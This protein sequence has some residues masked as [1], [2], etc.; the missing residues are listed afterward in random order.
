[1]GAAAQLAHSN[2]LQDAVLH[3]L[4]PV[5]VLI[6]HLP[7]TAPYQLSGTATFGGV[8]WT[9]NPRHHIQHLTG[10]VVQ[11][12]HGA[13]SR[14]PGRC[15]SH[16]TDP[17]PQARFQLGQ[18][19]ILTLWGTTS[20]IRL[21]PVPH[22]YGLWWASCFISSRPNLLGQLGRPL[23]HLGCIGKV[24]AD[25]STPGP[26]PKT[27]VLCRPHLDCVGKVQALR[28]GC[29]P[30]QG[31]EPVQVVARDVELAAGRLQ[32]AQLVQLLLRQ[33]THARDCGHLGLD[34]F[35]HASHSMRRR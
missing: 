28:G 30:G 35:S 34:L 5:V 3:I 18:T 10:T 6:Q 11:P 7:A 23:R 21:G 14:S 12:A 33:A 8:P 24:Q 25:V 27:L 32:R 13:A 17:K 2:E 16:S 15:A 9:V 1:M 22:T 20:E 26:N 31:R 29:P 4:Q 19:C